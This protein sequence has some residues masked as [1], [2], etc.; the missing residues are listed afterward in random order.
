[1]PFLWRLKGELKTKLDSTNALIAQTSRLCST[2]T[3]QDIAYLSRTS[4]SCYQN[5]FARINY[6]PLA[7]ITSGD[8]CINTFVNQI[9]VMRVLEKNTKLSRKWR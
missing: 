4:S 8:A 1:M 2:S 5:M 6:K 9:P 7:E 3:Y